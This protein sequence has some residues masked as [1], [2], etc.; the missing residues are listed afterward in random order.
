LKELDMIYIGDMC[1]LEKCPL[2]HEFEDNKSFV[3]VCLRWLFREALFDPRK[4]QLAKKAKC[5]GRSQY[6][7]LKEVI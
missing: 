3:Y 7:A 5:E 4:N 1:K 6:V 2:L